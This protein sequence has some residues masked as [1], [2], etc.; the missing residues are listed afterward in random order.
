M[1]GAADVVVPFWLLATFATART[2]YHYN[3]QRRM[4]ELQQLADQ[5]AAVAQELVPRPPVVRGPERKLL[6]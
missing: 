3:S 2:V 4:R 5:L 6:G 1:P